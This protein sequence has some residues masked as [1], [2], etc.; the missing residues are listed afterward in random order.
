VCLDENHSADDSNSEAKQ[1]RRIAPNISGSTIEGRDLGS[2][3]TVCAIAACWSAI[4]AGSVDASASS[5][6]GT[7]LVAAR[8]DKRGSGRGVGCHRESGDLRWL[9]RDA[10]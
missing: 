10:S 4:R 9:E 6:G 3:W 2:G 7:S 8:A 1:H 5:V